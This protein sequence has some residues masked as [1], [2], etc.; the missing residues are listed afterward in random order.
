VSPV[1]VT[2]AS[3]LC[4]QQADAEEARLTNNV[5]PA[6][7]AGAGERIGDHPTTTAILA[8]RT[9]TRQDAFSPQRRVSPGTLA[10]TGPSKSRKHGEYVE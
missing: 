6:E 8:I 5:D 3:K 2:D 10:T 1:V 7:S 4:E 9:S